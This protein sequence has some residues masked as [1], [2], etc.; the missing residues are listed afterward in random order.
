MTGERSGVQMQIWDM[1]KKALYTH[2]ACHSLN[3]AILISVLLHQY[4]IALA[5]LKELQFE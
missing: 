1:Q 2:Y 5:K 3:L 4:K